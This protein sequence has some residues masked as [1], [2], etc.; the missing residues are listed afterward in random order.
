MYLKYGPVV[1]GWTPQLKIKRLAMSFRQMH[2]HLA[3]V[4]GDYAEL[5]EMQHTEVKGFEIDQLRQFLWECEVAPE[6]L[7]AL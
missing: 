7:A 4:L 2:V 3:T 1:P 6:V 5:N